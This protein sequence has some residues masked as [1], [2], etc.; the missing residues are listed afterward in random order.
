MQLLAEAVAAAATLFLCKQQTH[1]QSHMHFNHSS[2]RRSSFTIHLEPT[3][4]PSQWVPLNLSIITTVCMMEMNSV[5]TA[6]TSTNIFAQE[7]EQKRRNKQTN[8]VFYVHEVRQTRENRKYKAKW[9]NG[10][11]AT[12]ERCERKIIVEVK[13]N[14][15][16][17]RIKNK[18]TE[19]K[20]KKAL[21]KIAACRKQID[22]FHSFRMADCVRI[23]V[24]WMP[25]TY[26]FD[27]FVYFPIVSGI[28]IATR[29]FFSPSTDLVSLS[30]D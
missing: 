11:D 4:I 30:S 16:F 19:K 26:N 22:G 23:P 9:C 15:K 8:S 2:S 25:T 28:N 18:D 29:F 27:G 21:Q 14:V 6:A 13:M 24:V 20:K 12:I 5:T 3:A 1:T 10:V 7:C 17:D